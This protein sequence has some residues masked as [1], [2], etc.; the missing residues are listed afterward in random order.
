MM[1]AG[2]YATAFYRKLHEVLH[3]E[4]RARKYWME[5][6]DLLGSPGE[7]RKGHLRRLAAMFYHTVSLP[8]ARYQLKQLEK[9]PHRGIASLPEGMTQ[10]E[11]ARPTPQAQ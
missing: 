3:K 5:F 1:Y 9:A 10:E 8:L 6:K 4:Y 2:P 7:F 11:A